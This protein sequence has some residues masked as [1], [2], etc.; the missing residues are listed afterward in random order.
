[1][2]W[3][4]QLAEGTPAAGTRDIIGTHVFRDPRPFHP[5]RLHAALGER[6]VPDVV[7]RILRSRGFV[8]LA[9]RPDRVGIWSTAGDIL[10]LDPTSM[11][12][13]DPDSPIGQEI[14]FFGLDLDRAA[15]DLTLSSCLLGTDEL[16]AGP[17]AWARYPDPFPKWGIHHHHSEG[18]AGAGRPVP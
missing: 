16:E 12:G 5:E 8:R 18:L 17:T 9:T 10:D 11:V 3:Q 14:V 6:L 13:W 7:G 2:G 1:M 15:P 4:Q